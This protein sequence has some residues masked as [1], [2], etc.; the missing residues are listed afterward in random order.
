MLYCRGTILLCIANQLYILIA[1]ESQ[2]GSLS[3]MLSDPTMSK[4]L[5]GGGGGGGLG[6]AGGLGGGL[7]GLGGGLGLGGK[8]MF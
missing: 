1:G 7:G 2:L 6:A 4:L 3:E 5:M 8:W